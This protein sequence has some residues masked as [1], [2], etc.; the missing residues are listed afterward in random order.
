VGTQISLI[1][2]HKKRILEGVVVVS[3][4]LLFALFIHKQ[5]FLL[6]LA[7]LGLLIS[8]YVIHLATKDVNLFRSFG[9]IGAQRQMPIYLIIALILGIVLGIVTRNR[10]DLTL[11]PK[12]LTRIAIIA[13]LVGMVEEFVFRGVIQGHVRPAGRVF[14]IL[15]AASGHTLY[16]LFVIFS[17]SDHSGFNFQIL[18]FWTLI[19]GI[20]LGIFRELSRS[21]IPPAVGHACFDIIL[22]GGFITAPF[23]VWG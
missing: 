18:A 2:Q 16:K 6:I 3:G 21:V 22:Y 20:L 15:F 23:W 9:F 19:V 8:S 5:N 14:A 12:T 7:F 1:K 10:F 4:I 11:I 13:P 17:L